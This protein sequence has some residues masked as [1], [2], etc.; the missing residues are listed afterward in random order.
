MLHEASGIF[1][2]R[3]DPNHLRHEIDGKTFSFFDY[4]ICAG[5]SYDDRGFL[6]WYKE[7]HPQGK[8]IA[9]D[10]RQPYYLGDEDLW[11]SG[12]IQEIL[13]AVLLD[14]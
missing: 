8:I 2:Y 5:L 7:K 9:I 12:D 1:P 6:G 14:L 13:P 4:I 11:I 10:L 3:V